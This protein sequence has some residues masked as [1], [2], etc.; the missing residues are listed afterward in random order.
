MAGLSDETT[1]RIVKAAWTSTFKGQV[2]L[3]AVGVAAFWAWI[4]SYSVMIDALQDAG[5]DP[6]QGVVAGFILQ[7]LIGLGGAFAACILAPLLLHRRCVERRVRRARSELR[8]PVCLYG[9][10]ALLD[11]GQ[12]RCPECA[13]ELAS[14]HSAATELE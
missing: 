7:M 5:I 13:F 6:I 8:C 12:K 11:A 4:Y 2:V 1:R 10:A 3:C 14:F 9:V